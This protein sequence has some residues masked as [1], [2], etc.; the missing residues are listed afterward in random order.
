MVRWETLFTCPYTFLFRTRP[1]TGTVSGM[2]SDAVRGRDPEWHTH[3]P[4]ILQ[5]WAARQNLEIHASGILQL[6]PY[7]GW[8][9]HSRNTNLSWSAVPH[10]KRLCRDSVVSCSVI[11][12]T[13]TWLLLP[14]FVL[15][16]GLFR[17]GFA[18]DGSH[19]AR[20][21]RNLDSV[22][23]KRQWNISPDHARSSRQRPQDTVQTTQDIVPIVI[24]LDQI[25]GVS[26]ML[27][28]APSCRECSAHLS[29]PF[30]TRRTLLR[31]YSTA[32]SQW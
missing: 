3:E 25:G 23:N 24:R 4:F 29:G 32:F 19:S 17:N 5:T 30:P 2:A 14:N 15:L 1:L 21:G 11:V 31:T 22:G 28:D 9:G 16:T 26:R 7:S 20:S 27:R 8:S 12:R 10:Y 6:S 18:K 13:L